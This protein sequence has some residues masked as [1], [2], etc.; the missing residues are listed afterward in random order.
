MILTGPEIRAQVANGIEDVKNGVRKLV[1]GLDHENGETMD[2]IHIDPYEPDLVGPNSVDLRLG[3]GLLVYGRELKPVSGNPYDRDARRSFGRREGSLEW[4]PPQHDQPLDMMRD[5]P[6]MEIP[7]TESIVLHP[8]I[9]YLARTIETIGSNK[10]VPIVEG[11]SSVGRL[12]IHIHVTAGFCD[13]GFKGTI[14]LEIH[15]IH[16][17]RIYP[18]VPI[19]QAYF[20]K[21]DGAIELYKGRYQ[22]QEEPTAS[23]FSLPKDNE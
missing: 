20:L 12:G 1:R 15:V 13:I 17:V 22:N 2:Y 9:L 14:T 8:G 5:N 21:P 18:G 19:C 16:P 23:R 4:L 6:T 7:F 3:E 11:R 10:F